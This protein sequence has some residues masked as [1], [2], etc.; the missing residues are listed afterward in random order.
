MEI[1]GR[2]K[3]EEV[4]PSLPFLFYFPQR[5]LGEKEEKMKKITLVDVLSGRRTHVLREELK[6]KIIANREAGELIS[7]ATCPFCQQECVIS[8]LALS[9]PTKCEHW[10]QWQGSYIIFELEIEAEEV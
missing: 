5:L 9:A 1:P 10:Q 2:N 6:A 3:A 4:Q 8:T 7:V